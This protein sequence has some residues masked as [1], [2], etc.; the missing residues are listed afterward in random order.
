[1]KK[2]LT[3]IIALTSFMISAKAQKGNNQL[4]LGG[5]AA[6]PVSELGDVTKTGFGFS[7]KGMYGIGTSSQQ[8]TFEAGFNRF[9]VKNLPSGVDGHY[10]AIPI[11]TGYRYLIGG[12]SLEPQAGISINR[13]V[14]S[15]GNQTVSSSE[16]NFGWATSIG[17]E[18]NNIELS[19][20]YQSSDVK[21]S[22][23]DLTFVGVRL[24]CNFGL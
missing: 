2:A 13:V 3:F 19:V 16:A 14:G 15:A 18:F 7:G 5:Q 17:Y 23:V 24:A 9:T 6:F 12:L 22:D 20:R 4:Q 21:D 8:V 10:S 1:M 11:Y